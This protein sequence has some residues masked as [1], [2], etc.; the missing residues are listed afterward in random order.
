MAAL[1]SLRPFSVPVTLAQAGEKTG[2]KAGNKVVTNHHRSTRTADDDDDGGARRILVGGPGADLRRALDASDE[3]SSVMA[4]FRSRALRSSEEHR[5][6][7]DSYAR[8]LDDAAPDRIQRILA[9]SWHSPNELARMLL[10]HFP[11]VSDRW[12]ALKVLISQRETLSTEQQAALDIVLAQAEAAPPE[13]VRERLA[14]IHCAI[15]ARLCSSEMPLACTPSMLRAA[16]RN[17]LCDEAG[18]IEVYQNWIGNFG[19]ARRAQVLHFMEGALVDDMRANDPSSTA[20]EFL[21]PLTRLG[22]LRRLRT[23]ESTFVAQISTSPMARPFNDREQDWLHFLLAILTDPAAL[24]GAL[25]D[26]T[27]DAAMLQGF[28]AHSQ[29]IGLLQRACSALPG[30]PLQS[31]DARDA[32]LDGLSALAQTAYRRESVATHADPVSRD[33][34]SA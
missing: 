26:V 23:C 27:G 11:D 17:F 8:L 5:G 31:Q 12:L 25:R 19:F 24:D 22:V 21:L 18:D 1:E 13:E 29:L 28:E 16:Y 2:E 33:R 14:G 3:M 30:E 7:D 10:T 34:R 20:R 32:V 6:V 9:A 15:K 4:Q